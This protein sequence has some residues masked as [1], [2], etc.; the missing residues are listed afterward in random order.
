M[1]TPDD[2]ECDV[3]GAPWCNASCKITTDTTPGANPITEMWI[4]IPKLSTIN[5]A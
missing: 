5:K 1:G 3:R 4:K 2:E